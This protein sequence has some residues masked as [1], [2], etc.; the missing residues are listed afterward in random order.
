MGAARAQLLLRRA[1]VDLQGVSA[2]LEHSDTKQG[3]FV[4]G[5]IQL[6][7]SAISDLNSENR[8]R[9]VRT[10]TAEDVEF[11]LEPQDEDIPV[12]GNVLAS[13]DDEEDKAAEDDVLERVKHNIW[14]WCCVKVSAIWKGIEGTDYLGCCSYKDEEDFKLHSGYY[15]DMKEAALVDLNEE[16]GRRWTE[17]VSL[18]G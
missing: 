3:Q 15:E 10:L 9:A 14:A 5:A 16:V 4:N 8:E 18:V 1:V 17:I 7:E 6:V 11:R 2:A 13:G 12:R